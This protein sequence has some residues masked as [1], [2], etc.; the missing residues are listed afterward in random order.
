M[1]RSW[2]QAPHGPRIYITFNLAK[3]SINPVWD[4][5]HAGFL[6]YIKSYHHICI[7]IMIEGELTCY[8][9]FGKVLI[10]MINVIIDKRISNGCSYYIF[11]LQ[12]V[13]EVA[14]RRY[15]RET[16]T[17]LDEVKRSSINKK[18]SRGHRIVMLLGYSL[19]R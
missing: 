6:A 11:T 7:V 5:I 17:F 12:F 14:S 9:L 19:S 1:S 16:V 18:E 13:N 10:I 2:V 8:S 15:L 4:I 3:Y